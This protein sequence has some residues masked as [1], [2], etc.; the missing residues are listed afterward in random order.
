M[1][2]ARFGEARLDMLFHYFLNRV[3]WWV[4]GE[5]GNKTNLSPARAS[6][7]GLSLATT[8]KHI[9]EGNAKA[10]EDLRTASDKV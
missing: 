3:G 5:V 7:Q 10:T 6:R 9:R 1:G 4:V 8:K 2:Q